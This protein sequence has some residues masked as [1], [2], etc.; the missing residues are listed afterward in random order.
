MYHA[1]RYRIE[2]ELRTREVNGNVQWCYDNFINP[3]SMKTASEIRKQL[4]GY[5]EKLGLIETVELIWIC[6]CRVA[7]E[8]WIKSED[9]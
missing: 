1:Y 6:E 3:R 7:K 2:K 8:S 4:V 5:C 9:A